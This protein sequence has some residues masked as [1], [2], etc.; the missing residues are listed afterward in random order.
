MLQPPPL[1]DYGAVLTPRQ[2]ALMVCALLGM[3]YKGSESDCLKV[4][5][6]F[7][8]KAVPL[9][10]PIDFI[11]HL[12]WRFPALRDG[13]IFSFALKM[14][15]FEAVIAVRKANINLNLPDDLMDT[16]W[17]FASL[18]VDALEALGSVERVDDWLSGKADPVD[19]DL[20]PYLS[21]A[22]GRDVIKA[23]LSDMSVKRLHGKKAASIGQEG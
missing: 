19:L 14:S 15:I 13:L 9:D 3:K 23:K 22:F 5:A 1:P 11:G 21:S 8:R 20:G 6:F 18:M 17:G 16:I 2:H 12:C 7:E 4:Y 10:E